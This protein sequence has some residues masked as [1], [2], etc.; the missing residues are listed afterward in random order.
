MVGNYLGQHFGK[1]TKVEESKIVLREIV[2][3]ELGDWVAR[4]N[5]LKLQEKSK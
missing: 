3:D 5:T 2:Q 1:V 4:P